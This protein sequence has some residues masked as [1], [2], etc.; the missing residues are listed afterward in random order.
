MGKWD[1]GS[2][3]T[4]YPECEGRVPAHE[5]PRILASQT[6]FSVSEVEA[7][8]QLFKSISSSLVDDELISKEEFLLALFKNKW[9]KKS[10]ANRIFSLF[11][12]KHKGVVFII[13]DEA[14]I[15]LV[16]GIQGTEVAKQS[17]DIIILDDDFASVVKVLSYFAV[18]SI[19]TFIIFFH[20]FLSL[21]ILYQER[22]NRSLRSYYR[23]GLN[24]IININLHLMIQILRWN[25]VKGCIFQLLMLV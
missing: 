8:F 7:L 12:V 2:L 17:S 24:G 13:L 18:G 25:L 21:I 10:F 14:D 6:S 5:D 23:S 11:D 15:G 19:T 22:V 1:V 9:K 3:L 4:S 16:M 20:Q